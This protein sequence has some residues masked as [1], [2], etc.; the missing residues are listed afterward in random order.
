MRQEDKDLLESEGWTVTCELPFELQNEEYESEA[1]G[2]AAE[3]VLDFLK[4]QQKKK[5]R[6]QKKLVLHL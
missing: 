2:L 3:L 1:T 5:Q 6:L 4:K